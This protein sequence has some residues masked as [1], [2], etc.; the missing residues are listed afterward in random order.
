MSDYHYA[1]DK[2]ITLEGT[3]KYRVSR[4][5]DLQG[6]THQETLYYCNTPAQARD[7]ADALNTS[8]KYNNIQGE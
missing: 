8:L 2:V 5:Y 6:A 3:D 1:W 4:V 7:I